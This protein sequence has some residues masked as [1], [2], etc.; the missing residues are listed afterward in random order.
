[1]ASGQANPQPGKPAGRNAVKR[2]RQ[3][4]KL[5]AP[6]PPVRFVRVVYCD[7]SGIIRSKACHVRSLDLLEDG[8]GCTAATPG[9]PVYVDGPASGSDCSVVG[10]IRLVPDGCR[11]FALPYFP[12]HAHVMGDFY[13]QGAPMPTCPRLV[14]KRVLVDA[15]KE[16]LQI[17]ASFEEEFV[18]LRRDKTPVE[19][20]AYAEVQ[21]MDISA[22]VVNELSEAI[23]ASG[24]L[25][26]LY[27]PE[28]AP[29]QHEMSWKYVDA[30]TAAD[31]HVIFRETAHAVALKHELLV[32]FLPKIFPS[33]AGNG[34]H[35]HMSI[36]REGVNVFPAGDSSGEGGVSELGLHFLGG[37]LHHLPALLALTAASP[38]SYRRLVPNCWAGAAHCWGFDNREA[39]IRVPTRP[40]G[41]PTNF[42]YKP[43]DS[44]ANPHLALAGIIAAGLDG[45]RS[46]HHPG[47]PVQVDPS[48]LPT[49]QRPPK[50]PSTLEEAVQCLEASEL[51]RKALGPEVIK[52]YCALK[53]ADA[54]FFGSKSFAEEVD[55]LLQ[56]Y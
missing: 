46:R 8:I 45:I 34:A 42:E 44:T 7:L 12:S 3:V 50:L 55:F 36:W 11:V 41:H 4:L 21:A 23:A 33:A 18:L 40:S 25:P 16:G 49:E 53:R 24:M 9:F 22:A 54:A 15:A 52:T 6:A 48:S 39:A 51:L 17:H 32:S 26:E 20:T 56:K 13:A 19:L 1:M 27:H 2:I 38:N 47:A 5:D 31:N 14:L 37:V 30:L 29:G 10:D 35:I 28:S 43:C